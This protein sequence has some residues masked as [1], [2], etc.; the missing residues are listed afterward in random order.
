MKVKARVRRIGNSLGI[1][2]PSEEASANGLAEGDSVEIEVSRRASV[3]E[4]FGTAKFD[5]T[6]QEIKDE[7]RE[8]WGD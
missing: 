8:G 6:A 7:A 1:I 5:R 3:R 4:L 2:I